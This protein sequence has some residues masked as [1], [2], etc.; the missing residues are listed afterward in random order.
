MPLAAVRERCATN[1]PACQYAEPYDIAFALIALAS[2]AL[3]CPARHPEVGHAAIERPQE[4]LPAISQP[5]T[6]RDR[7]PPGNL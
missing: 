3:S 1:T 4:S 7:L 5:S 6:P 2:L